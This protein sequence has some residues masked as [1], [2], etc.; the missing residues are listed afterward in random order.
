M[1]RRRGEEDERREL[2]EAGWDLVEHAA[3]G[4][5]VWRNPESGHLY[6][7]EAALALVRERA[8]RGEPFGEDKEYSW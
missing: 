4:T 8:R 3:D 1:T 5:P 2:E 7:Q 6:P